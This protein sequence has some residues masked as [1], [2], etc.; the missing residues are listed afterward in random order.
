VV[1]ITPNSP[2]VPV[3]PVHAPTVAPGA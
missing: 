2:F 3:G 1:H